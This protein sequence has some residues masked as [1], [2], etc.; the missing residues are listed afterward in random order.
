MAASQ[1][2]HLALEA[3]WHDRMKPDLKDIQFSVFLPLI[4][5]FLKENL[6]ESLS[7]ACQP[8]FVICVDC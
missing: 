8:L 4:C 6:S 1:R 3:S 7:F 2:F 5:S